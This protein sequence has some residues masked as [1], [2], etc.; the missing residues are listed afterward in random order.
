MKS[1]TEAEVTGVSSV[2][3]SSAMKSATEAEVTGVSSVTGSSLAIG[4]VCEF[5]FIKDT[6]F[7]AISCIRGSK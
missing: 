4:G 2:T 7:S 5:E 1:A 3:G 6:L